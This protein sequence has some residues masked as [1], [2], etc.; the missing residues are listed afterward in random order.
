MK[1]QGKRKPRG[2]SEGHPG[3]RAGGWAGQKIKA[4]GNLWPVKTK[5]LTTKAQ[6]K[7]ETEPGNGSLGKLVQGGTETLGST[8]PGPQQAAGNHYTQDDKTGGGTKTKKV[9]RTPHQKNGPGAETFYY[10]L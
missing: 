10:R 6:K 9:F 7:R 5:Q 2:D 1:T 3:E 8:K 4:T